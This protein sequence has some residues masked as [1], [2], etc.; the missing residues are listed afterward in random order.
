M[1]LSLLLLTVHQVVDSAVCTLHMPRPHHQQA[2]VLAVVLY[3][4]GAQLL[5]MSHSICSVVKSGSRGML[6]A[7]VAVA[8]ASSTVSGR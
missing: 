2:L 4:A 6:T 5:G 8:R 3:S 1:V 7:A